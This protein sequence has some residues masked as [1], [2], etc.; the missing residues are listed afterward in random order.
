MKGYKKVEIPTKTYEELE[1][2]AEYHGVT[3][4]TFTEIFFSG[5]MV[6]LKQARSVRE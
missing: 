1:R 6:G 4:D 2:A 5:V 3:L